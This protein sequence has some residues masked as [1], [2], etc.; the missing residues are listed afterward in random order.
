MAVVVLVAASL[1][2]A[3]PAE[4]AEPS[5]PS[6]SP[7]GTPLAEAQPK[8]PARRAASP[9]EGRP[10]KDIRIEGADLVSEEAI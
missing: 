2:S 4:G 10:I 3:R 7:A 1:G 5:A 8:S 6:A 9:E